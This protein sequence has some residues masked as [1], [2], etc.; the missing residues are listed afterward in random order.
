MFTIILL[1]FSQHVTIEEIKLFCE[2]F[3]ETYIEERTKPQI[4]QIQQV[5]EIEN[6]D[7]TKSLIITDMPDF[8]ERAY[9]KH[10]AGVAYFHSYNEMQIFA[11]ASYAVM[12]LEGVDYAYL[13]RVYERFHNIPWTI[14]KTKRC[15]IREMTLEDIDALYEIY[16]DKSI[17]QYMEDLFEDK[18]EEKAY[19][20][21][22]IHN[23]YGF[24]GFGMWMVQRISDGKLLGRAG[25]SVRDGYEDVELGYVIRTDE[26]KKGYATEVCTA[27]L[28]YAKEELEVE[29]V[30]AFVLPKNVISKNFC[31]KLGFVKEG[32][33]TIENEV[34]DFYIWRR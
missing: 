5:E 3:S 8:F 15:V 32:E 7:N 17:T 1:A 25:L 6:F 24:Y 20:E 26:Q 10:M 12:G 34:H 9:M 31:E 22:Y 16:A 27:I 23:M 28:D 19:M 21:K 2:K 13:N 11:N 29:R 33:Q 14:L 4:E 30:N 18:N